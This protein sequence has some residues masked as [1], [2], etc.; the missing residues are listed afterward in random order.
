MSLT[1]EGKKKMTFRMPDYPGGARYV[2]IV[3]YNRN[4]AD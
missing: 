2:T 3:L 1:Y 4:M